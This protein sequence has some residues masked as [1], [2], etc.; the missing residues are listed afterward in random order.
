MYKIKLI[1]KKINKTN[2]CTKCHI[3]NNV[4]NIKS[5]EINK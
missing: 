1:I 3:K 2:N 5:L 4:D